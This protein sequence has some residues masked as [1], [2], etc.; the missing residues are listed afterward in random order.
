MA[1]Y[2]QKEIEKKWQSIWKEKKVFEPKADNR[3]KYFI[4]VA[5][6][7]A[8][9]VMHI[10]HGR[11]FTMADIL[12][13]FQRLNGKNV[14]YPMAFHISGTPVLAVADGIARGDEKQIKQTKD[15]I[16][17]Y[18][19]DE[20][21]Q[22][23]LIESFKD[24]YKIAE[25]FSGK[26]EDT[27][28]SI[29]LSIDWTRQFSTGDLTYRK[30]IEWQYKKLYDLGIL[31][32]S[33]Y[34]ILYSVADK[35][36]V[37]EDDI[38]D[39]DLDKVSISEMT[40]ILFKID[41]SNNEYI[42]CATLRPD[43]IFGATNIYAKPEM[44][45]VKLK[46][47][48]K[49]WYV[50]KEAQ[51][52]VEHQFDNVEFVES[53]KGTDLIGKEVIV[54]ILDKKVPVYKADFCDENHG[55]GLVYSSPADSVH[56]Y[57]Y[58][59]ETLFPGEKLENYIEKEPLGLIPITKTFDK[60][61]QEVKY[62]YDIP[63]YHKLFEHKI[64][65]SEGNL[66]RLEE[67]KQE[68]YKEAHFGAVMINCGEEFDNTPLKAN[69]GAN[70][71]KEK[72]IDLDLGGTYY[73]TSRRAVTR[74]GDKVIVANLDGQW[75]LNYKDEE[76]KQKAYDVLDSL[77]FLPEKLRES[78]RGY[79]KWVE[80]R[81]CARKRGIGTPLPFDE[82][83]IIEPLSD[84]TIYQMLYLVHHIIHRENISP[85]QLS[86]EVFDYVFLGKGNST[87]IAEENNIEKEVLDEMRTEVTYW[88]GLDVRYTNVGHMSNHLSFLIYHYGLIFPKDNWPKNITIGGY[89]IKDGSKISKSKGNGIPLMRMGDTYGVDMY[90]L[91]VAIGANFEIEMD[92][93]DEEIYQLEKK[94]SK[95]KN[96]MLDS[97]SFE[98]VE[99]DLFDSLDKWLISRF[100]SRAKEYFSMMEN[101]RIREA[102]VNVLYE[103]LNDINYHERR[104]G[105]EKTLKVIRYIVE[106]YIKLM[107]PVTPHFSEEVNSL[108]NNNNFISLEAFDK[109]FE[110]YINEDVEKLE[111]IGIN[112]I[113]NVAKAKD[114]KKIENP[115]NITLVIANDLRYDLFSKLDEL[116]KQTRNFKELFTEISNDERFESEMKF[117]QKF[118]P[119]TLK[120][121][122][123]TYVGKSTELTLL[124]DIVKYLKDEYN[125]TVEIVSADEINQTVNS[126]P[127]DP[128]IIIE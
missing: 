25:F 106:D 115:K 35:N 65:S 110:K 58:L 10:G 46:V 50:S 30:F 88:K 53:L 6:P 1:E 40:Y 4:T 63:A 28:D 3:E 87:I 121:G 24:P 31:I 122:L 41:S 117:V 45:L 51:V 100:Y 36:A 118:L 52:K 23:E 123:T 8:N 125:C 64:F 116:L 42:V 16:S 102:Y 17:D 79:L 55:T 34:P 19:K 56:D 33:K 57:L 37:G 47:G 104:S 20:S 94:F 74:G 48:D 107:T 72:L 81:P 109:N 12:A 78:Q 39:G 84:S 67:I 18:I 99:Y 83:W 124:D 73:E 97:L 101:M 5:Y 128:A 108:L 127:G 71:V 76:I 85:N 75:F 15:A 120:D 89:L 59:F 113:S 69:A 44:D 2:N 112:I 105:I 38:K 60:K 90:R 11:T 95:W 114:A 43:S 62:K 111:G 13:R 86:L 91:Y 26:I 68:L 96:L 21:S 119:K 92:F 80:M 7:Y 61:G 32:Q 103:M 66:D 22:N 49:Y 29:G 77:E 82:S 98:K 27:F 9:S 126:I 70:K 93:R 14:L 54:P